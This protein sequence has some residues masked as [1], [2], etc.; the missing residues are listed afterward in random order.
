MLIRAAKREEEVNELRSK[1]T[2]ELNEEVIDL[3]GE[4]L[5]SG[6]RG[7]PDRSSNLA[8]SDACENG[9]DSLWLSTTN[10]R[11]LDISETISLLIPNEDDELLDDKNGGRC[12]QAEW[13]ILIM[14][15]S[16]M[17]ERSTNTFANID[18]EM[19]DKK[20]SNIARI[21][22]IKREREIEQGIGK[23]LS[24]KL[25]KQWKKSIVVRPAPSLRKMLEKDNKDA[26]AAK[27]S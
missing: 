25:D 3:K 15:M 18:V 21:L 27:S 2:E 9:F 12:D 14:I 23:R 1:T 13:I 8:N 4:L 19:I 5:C 20:A 24:R 17:V 6:F 26:D 10:I 11:P 7:P 22:T 16:W